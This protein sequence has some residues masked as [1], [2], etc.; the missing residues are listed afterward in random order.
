VAGFS[1]LA[2]MDLLK[3]IAIGMGAAIFYIFAEIG[4]K[5]HGWK[6]GLIEAVI[7]STAL[8]VITLLTMKFTLRN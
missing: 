7:A 1:V 6:R 2:G 8:I 5:Q 4:I 3:S